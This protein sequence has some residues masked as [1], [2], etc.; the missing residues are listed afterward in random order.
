MSCLS[1]ITCLYLV[2]L[3]QVMRHDISPPLTHAMSRVR[4]SYPQASHACP[5]QQG[6]LLRRAR[7]VQEACK[8]R[9]R[10]V[11]VAGTNLMAVM[12]VE[13]NKEPH[14]THDGNPSR[15]KV[16]HRVEEEG[17]NHTRQHRPAL[18]TSAYV[19]AC[20]HTSQSHT[21]IPSRT[22]YVHN[23]ANKHSPK[24][25]RSRSTC[26]QCMSHAA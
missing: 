12:H 15:V 4:G 7:G 13:G 20:Q 9:A 2:S 14:S 25:Q 19:S 18:H 16:R 1:H 3:S 17:R 6:G 23:T 26:F 10:G 21:T 24:I 5:R 11:Y 22:A 8:R